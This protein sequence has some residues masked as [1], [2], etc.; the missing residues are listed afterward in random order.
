[1]ANFASRSQKERSNQIPKNLRLFLIVKVCNAKAVVASA[2]TIGDPAKPMN[3][4][5]RIRRLSGPVLLVMA[6]AI[7]IVQVLVRP[8]VGI[9]NNGDFPTMAGALGLGPEYGTWNSH[10]QYGEFVYRYIRADRY[11]YN[12]GFRTAE[13]LSSEF[14]FIKTARWLQKL[15]QPGPQ[16]DI[17]WLGAVSGTFFLLAIGLGIYALPERWRLWLGPFLVLI[18]TDVAY[19]Q[20][21]NSFY[22]D[23]AG[24]IFLMLC[25]AAALHVVKDRNSRVFPLIMVAAAIL[26]AASKSQHSIPALLLVP[27]FW[28]FVFWNRGRVTRAI[29]IAGSVLLVLVA[30]MVIGRNSP[31]Y[32]ATALYTTIFW[33]IT[34][35]IPDP[36]G[37]L[38]ELG[39]NKNDLHFVHTF[40]Y[41]REAGSSDP[42]WV[43]QFVLR[44]NYLKLLQ[45]YLRHPSVPA[46]LAYGDLGDA[47]TRMRPFANR[48]LDDGFKPG[49]QATDFTYWTDLRSSLFKHAP[50]H[51][52]VLA[53]LSTAGAVWLWRS[54]LD[55]AFAGVVFTI[56]AL[57]IMECAIAV[58]ADAA[59]TNRHLFIFHVATEIVILLL[60]VLVA[61][62][63]ALHRSRRLPNENTAAQS[64]T[65]CA[66]LP[67]AAIFL[68]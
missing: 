14:F 44:C 66:A 54:P 30:S 7:L 28:G 65:S 24:M 61:R 17:R 23:C 5:K 62:I 36:L 13:Y 9:S 26:F 59:E 3:N 33:R 6:A 12:R 41:Q 40:A 8:A 67:P 11:N 45:Y 46:R 51:I 19:V 32:R 31:V 64:S 55:R 4:R 37:A 16:F 49:T 29:W 43:R 63:Y 42:E 27:L 38:E 58:L 34:P 15:F 56:Q 68:G 48:S 47:A 39:L 60:P 52:F 57:A 53:L 2:M 35:N 18:W 20:Y 10:K 22:M 25:M 21:L 1:M 50:W